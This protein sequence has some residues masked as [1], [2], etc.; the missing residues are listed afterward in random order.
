[1]GCAVG[2]RARGE[3]GTARCRPV[4]PRPA[5]G[6]RRAA[7]RGRGGP[8]LRR[9]VVRADRSARTGSRRRVPSRARGAVRLCGSVAPDRA[10][11]SAD[12]R[13]SA[14]T[15]AGTGNNTPSGG[16]GTERARTGHHHLLASP[17]VGGG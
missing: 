4:V 14:R 16:G 15:R 11:R 13:S 1:G 12:G 7:L 6:S 17:R 5:R 10:R 3:R 2:A 9:A 8:A